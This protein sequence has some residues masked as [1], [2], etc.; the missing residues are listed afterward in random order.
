M[1]VLFHHTRC[2]VGAL[3]LAVASIALSAGA[4]AAMP[5]AGSTASITV[6]HPAVGLDNIRTPQ[7]KKVEITSVTAQRPAPDQLLLVVHVRNAGRRSIDLSGHTR[8][9][10]GPGDATGDGTAGPFGTQ[11]VTIEPGQEADLDFA[12]PATLQDGPWIASVTLT[13]GLYTATASA[14]VALGAPPSGTMSWVVVAF[15]VTGAGIL[16]ALIII[17][18]ALAARR[19]LA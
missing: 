14:S 8:L 19:L 4:S 9:T 3:A 18:T 5:S 16:I 7:Q 15:L 2:A 6:R 13:S 11:Q 12:L 1:R 10:D 17:A